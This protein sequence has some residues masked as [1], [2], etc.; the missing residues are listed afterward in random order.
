MSYD[1]GFLQS[2]PFDQ[3]FEAWADLIE[4]ARA[5]DDE[6]AMQAAL[7]RQ[8][9]YFLL[10]ELL[11][12]K[13]AVHPWL[14]E[15]S[16]A[17][18]AGSDGYLDLWARGHYK[19]LM[20]STRVM[21]ADGTERP[22]ADIQPG[23][24]VMGYDNLWRSVPVPVLAKSPLYR[25][26]AIEVRLKSGRKIT[27]GLEHPFLK[28]TGWEKAQ[29][30]Q[31]GDW[32]AVPGHIRTEQKGS[33]SDDEAAFLGYMGAEGACNGRCSFTNFDEEIVEDFKVVCERLGFVCRCSKAKGHRGLFNVSAGI[34][35]PLNFLKAHG[36][37]CLSINK[38]IPP[39]VM[40]ASEDAQQ[41]FLRAF[42]ACDGWVN[43]HA[44]QAGCTLGSPGLC[45]DLQNILHQQGIFSSIHSYRNDHAGAHMLVVS[46]MDNLKRLAAI[47]IG[48][49]AKQGQLESLLT[50]GIGQ[51]DPIPSGWETM[52]SSGPR[53]RK[54]RKVGVSHAGG[55]FTR[56]AKVR[57]FAEIDASEKLSALCD[58][59][60]RWDRIET[61]SEPFEEAC[62]DIQVG[63]EQAF[64]AEHI[65]THNSTIITFA[66]V[67]QEILR[68]PEITI[69]IFSH[70]RPIAKAFLVQ[71]KQEF[72]RNER[73][74]A[75][76]PEVLYDSP[77]KESPRWSEDGGIIVKRTSNPK[78]STLDAWG[79]VDGQPI[80][81][82]YELRVYD[83]VVTM[84]SVSTPE[85]VAK[86]TY[87]WEMSQNLGQPR[88]KN[89][90][91]HIGTRYSFADTYFTLL[92]RGA[93]I[94]RIRAAT[95][96]GTAEGN[97]VFLT[98]EAW[99]QK[100]RDE[101]SYT[102]ACQQLQNPASG[103]EQT[104][105]PEWL[106][107]YEVRPLT[108]NVAIL[109]D[110]ASSKKKTSDRTAMAVIGIDGAGNKYL[111]DGYCHRM[112]LSERWKAL[113]GLRAKWLRQPG[114]QTVKVGYERFGMQSDIE[115]FKEM[116]RLRPTEAFHIEELNWPKEGN[117][118]KKDRI[119]RL[120]PDFENW[121]FF[122]PYSGEPTRLQRQAIQG[123]Q[124][125]LVAKRI[126][127]TDENNRIY[128]LVEYLIDSEFLLFP[129]AP[130]E[131]FLDA[132]SRIYD[133]ELAPP[134]MVHRDDLEPDLEPE[135]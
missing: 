25:K 16:R 79:L 119:Q 95:D 116:M 50:A 91:W 39:D 98:P 49:K 15:Q 2:L 7:G 3:V 87:A 31:P 18:E 115:H 17:V 107:Y 92:E 9:R 67:L 63:G 72:E 54:F 123:G 113:K 125:H 34:R 82:H 120:Q 60:I 32:I 101:S 37:N 23:D 59:D 45:Y 6:P 21:M 86:T 100:I 8:D 10:V 127:Y 132:M 80:S 99:K 88:G 102:I 12:R 70:T 30:L 103:T 14:Y 130:H 118:S 44:R 76:Y 27:A 73:L 93:L 90:S 13:D 48:L 62:Y 24:S 33:L 75:L 66:G 84:E 114:V 53:A 22:I 55:Q 124:G 56:R 122:L 85:Q 35:K 20:R 126:R 61:I 109:C 71:I 134:Q 46:G 4:T 105:K 40:T 83:D 108:L 129:F 65:V 135:Y 69:A 104:F 81:K 131:D 77:K 29:D 57:Q 36:A 28:I 19:T 43:T 112:N 11:A 1:L 64:I 121:R 41:A 111:L 89:R 51:D 38:R 52:L 47:G 26:P 97:P 128:D 74:I 117:D 68:N 96:T 42:W 94:P 58:S 5:T 133:I 106:R 78:E 110:P